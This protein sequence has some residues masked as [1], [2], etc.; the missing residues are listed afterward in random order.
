MPSYSVPIQDT[1]TTRSGL[2][3]GTLQATSTLAGWVAGTLL[4]DS[5]SCSWTVAGKDMLGVR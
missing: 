4:G 3:F 1:S 2:T 5:T